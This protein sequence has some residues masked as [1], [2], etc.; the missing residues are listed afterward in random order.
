MTK[1]ARTEAYSC[2]VDRSLKPTLEDVRTALGKACDAWD[3]MEAHLSD[4]YGLKGSLHF[5]Y[6]R[7]YGWA[8]RFERAG[9]LALAMYPNHNRI[10]VQVILGRA[11]VAQATG[12]RLPSR[13]LKALSSS[14]P[15]P[16]ERWL[17]VALSSRQGAREMRSLLK[18]KLSRTASPSVAGRGPQIRRVGV[19]A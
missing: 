17:F 2:F 10:T 12:I 3:E 11:Q 9:K 19:L 15:Y 6:G 13:V 8:L 14:K 16:N 1:Q 4:A 18:L 5:L 7:R